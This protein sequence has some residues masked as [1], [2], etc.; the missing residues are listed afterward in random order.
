MNAQPHTPPAAPAPDFDLDALCAK[1][2][3]DLADDIGLDVAIAAVE[4]AR[5]FWRLRR[6]LLGGLQPAQGGAA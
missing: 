5:D 2:R 6:R 4:V 3:A 1:A